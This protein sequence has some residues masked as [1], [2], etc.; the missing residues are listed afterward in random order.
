MEIHR[1][2]SGGG[3]FYRYETTD[4]EKKIEFEVE[5]ISNRFAQKSGEI[6]QKSIIWKKKKLE[7]LKEF[8]G[9]SRHL[10]LVV[11]FS[12]ANSFASL[13]RQNCLYAVC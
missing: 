5:V 4:Q 7:C 3:I 11:N 9:R 1:E 6:L 8:E 10:Q 12:T 2:M 13:M